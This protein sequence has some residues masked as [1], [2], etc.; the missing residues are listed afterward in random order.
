MYIKK[1][2]PP[3][4]WIPFLIIAYNFLANL[5]NDIYLP[6]LPKMTHIFHTSSSTM[7]LTMTSWFA[8][9]AAPQL[10]L[11]PLTDKIGRRPVIIYGGVCFLIATLLCIFSPDPGILILGRFLQGV[12]V[13]SLNVTS[14]SILT[15]LYSYHQRSKVINLLAIFGTIAPLIGPILGGYIFQLFG[16]QANFIFIFFLVLFCV[17]GLI[18]KLPESNLS[19]N[20]YALN[21]KNI[22]MSYHAIL[23]D[24]N[25]LK[26]LIPYCLLL[27]GLVAYNTGASFII[28]D[29]FKIPPDLFGYIL[30]PISFSYLLGVFCIHYTGSRFSIHQ[31]IYFGLVCVCFSTILMFVINIIFTNTLLTFVSPMVIYA[32]GFSLCSSALINEIMSLATANKG[33]TAALLGFCMAMGCVS[34]NTLLSITYDGTVISIANLILLFSITSFITYIKLSPRT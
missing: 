29:K 26:F 5:S 17:L 27:A 7:Q 34:S 24:K 32:L 6:S 12:G 33:A 13:C 28:I 31:L 11:G 22:C 16:W 23:V 21:I 10:F 18:F 2:N 20:Y 15:D 30:F 9:V 8:G 1:E 19:P 4:P 25:F 3:T 14:Y